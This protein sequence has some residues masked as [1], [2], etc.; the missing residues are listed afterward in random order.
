MNVDMKDSRTLN[1]SCPYT[2]PLPAPTFKTGFQLGI[3][4]QTAL[5]PCINP[6][7]S[8]WMNQMWAGWNQALY[9]LS[10]QWYTDATNQFQGPGFGWNTPYQNAGSQLAN[11]GYHCTGDAE[12]DTFDFKM[13]FHDLGPGNGFRVTAFQRVHK[14]TN[15]LNNAAMT[16]FQMF[17]APQYQDVPEAAV[18]K[19]AVNPFVFVGNWEYAA[20]DGT[21]TW[22]GVA[23]VQGTPTEVW[24]DDD[25]AGKYEGEI[26]DGHVFGYDAFATIQDGVDAVAGSTVNVAAGTYDEQ[27]VINKSLTLQGAGDTTIVKPSSAAILTQVFSGLSAGGGTKQIAGI[28]VA[29]VSDGS[30]VTVKNLKVDESSVT[31]MPT[32]ADYLAGIFYRETGGTMDTVSVVGG[33]ALDSTSDR[34]Y[35]MYLSAATNTVSVEVKG[36]TITNFDKEGINAKGNTLTVNIHHNTITGRGPLPVGDEVQNGVDIGWAAVATVNYNTISNLEYVPETWWAAGILFNNSGGS[37]ANNNIITDCQ[38]GIIAQDSSVA[39]QA[40]T[41]TGGTVGREPMG[42]QYYTA[43][44]Y[45]VSFVGNT[46]SGVKDIPGW[47]EAAIMAQTYVAG[48][49][50]AI[51]IDNNQL[52]SGS[53]SADGI[54]IGDTSANDAAGSIAATITNNTVSSWVNGIRLFGSVAAGSTLM[55]N[56]LSSNGN[57]I[58]VESEVNAANVSASFNNIVCNTVYGANNAGIGTLDAT[59]NWWGCNDGPGAVGPGSGDK[60]SDNVT[61]DPWLVLNLSANP[62]S[63]PADGVSTSVITADMTKNSDGQDTS[64]Q[65]HIPDG[66]QIIFT[67]DT[68]S[69]ESPKTTTSGIATAVFTSSTNSSPATISAKAPTCY[70]CATASVSVNMYLP[71]PPP[72]SGGGGGGG[73]GGIPASVLAAAAPTATASACPLTLTV[74]MLGQ[75]T[76]ATMTSDGVLCEN[77]LAFDPPKHNSWEAKEGTKLTL[78]GNKVPQLIK[79]TTVGSSPPAVNAKTIGPTYEINAYASLNG[80]TPSPITISPLFTMSSAYDPNELPKN[81]SEVLLSYYPNPNQGWLA[82]GSE[83]V[84]AEVGQARGTLNYFVPDTLL[85]KLAKVAPNFEVSKLNINPTQTQPAQQVT[86]SVNVSNTGGTSGD[87]T[88]ELKVNGVVESTKQITLGAGANQI[89]SFTVA[90]DAI[91][92]YQIEIASLT[93]EFVVAGPPSINWW[94]IGGIIAAIILALAIWML[95]R[96]RRFS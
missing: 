12:Y 27:V 57:G 42:A 50:L 34:G 37:T 28:I 46:V 94:P 67:T 29:N 40:N 62:P 60:V 38:F 80:L 45:T 69:I 18:N 52:T 90:E 82:M 35:G 4:N 88:V 44:S 66:T 81:V 70:T 54:I 95:I 47:E 36:S 68:G 43:G 21:V 83:G 20:G 91:G 7:S 96:R 56:M 85:A 84:V 26:V 64:A 5:G 14:T 61:Y 51:T 77:C 65:G 72:I 89:V 73:I 6:R 8:A 33:G 22:G 25:W 17:D 32:G 23:A 1:W 53:T 15:P 87:Y 13:I 74:N 92:K 63:I 9:Y 59:N 93:G 55:G 86:I 10:Q 16:W 39:A 30:A 19:S 31:T 75:T 71:M 49:S 78:E 3:T 79:I 2:P 76:T 41:V 24:V 11:G 58:L 48:A